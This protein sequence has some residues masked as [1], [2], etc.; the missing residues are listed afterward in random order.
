MLFSCCIEGILT[1]DHRLWTKKLNQPSVNRAILSEKLSSYLALL[2]QKVRLDNAMGEHSVNIHAENLLI[3][4]LNG[5]FDCQLQNANYVREA[6]YPALDL[7]DPERKIAFQITATSKIEKVLHTLKKVVK[8]HQDKEFESIYVFIITEKQRPEYY[9]RHEPKIQEIL[10]DKLKFDLHTHIL[11]RKELLKRIK[12][13]NDLEKL[14]QLLDELSQEFKGL[15]LGK[16]P[17]PLMAAMT[18]HPQDLELASKVCLGLL[19]KRINVYSNSKALQEEMERT[20]FGDFFMYS[21]EDI[22]PS[23]NYC[24]LLLTPAMHKDQYKFK[25]QDP[26]FTQMYKRKDVMLPCAIGIQAKKFEEM[27][28]VED[29]LSGPGK[30]MQAAID[31]I[32]KEIKSREEGFKVRDYQDFLQVLNYYKPRAKFKRV[33]GFADKSSRVGYSLYKTQDRVTRQMEYYLYL[34][35]GANLK[36]TFKHLKATH[37]DIFLK[38]NTLIILLPKARHARNIANRK[39]EVRNKFNPTNLFFIDEFLLEFCTTTQF[40]DSPEAQEFL[41]IRNFVFPYLIND[42]ITKEQEAEWIEKGYLKNWLFYPDE[43]ILVIKGWGGIGKT[44]LAR[45][46]SDMYAEERPNAKVI[47]IESQEIIEHL[48]REYRDIE[49]MD[50]YHFYEANHNSFGQEEEERMTRDLFRI[51]LDNGNILVILDGLDEIISKLP[52]FDVNRFVQSTLSYVSGFGQGKIL[53]TCRNYFW[54]KTLPFDRDLLTLKLL[55]FD[56]LKAKAFFTARYPHS[57]KLVEKAMK[58]AQGFNITNNGGKEEFLPYVLDVVGKIVESDRLLL[59]KDASFDS[60]FLNPHYKNDYLLYRICFRET[61]RIQQIS[62]DKQ[63]EFLIHFATFFNGQIHENQLEEVFENSTLQKIDR[64]QIEAFKSHPLLRVA[65]RKI[66]FQYDFF[67]EFFKSLYLSRFIE[68]DSAEEPTSTLIHLLANDCKYDLGLVKEVSNRIH[69]TEWNEE[70]ILRISY[71]LDCIKNFQSPDFNKRLINKA[72]SGL[73]TLALTLNHKHKENNPEQN[74]QLMQDLFSHPEAQGQIERMCIFNL[75][76]HSIR[77]NLEGIQLNNCHI[78]SFDS[79]WECRFDEKT[80]FSHSTIVN[81]KAPT[82]RFSAQTHNF[83]NCQIDASVENVLQ[84]QIRAEKSEKQQVADILGKYLNFF[85][86]HGRLSPQYYEGTKGI[87]WRY[88]KLQQ[89]L[90]KAD[91]ITRALI[92]EGVLEEIAQNGKSKLQVSLPFKEEVYQFSREGTMSSRINELVDQLQKL[93]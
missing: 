87:K 81:L 40:E 80:L 49:E 59:S 20:R 17:S 8:Y 22:P 34:Y 4:L 62:V 11:D 13:E 9:Q 79:F 21:Q 63:V 54:D 32:E 48:M 2:E 31:R 78:D 53:I 92:H 88:G 41:N 28:F 33:D 38:R 6:N 42:R 66:S 46:V 93:K 71:V 89:N 5:V 15:E 30:G 44:T 61:K 67:E 76:S 51:H 45:S 55:P 64:A 39:E 60:Q 57:P 65:N 35:E 29:I 77:F 1:V 72:L 52:R 85:F 19:E 83:H 43:P 91:K 23:V 16:T 37:K 69:S 68:I 12:A 47:F 14:E 70:K 25:A 3:K 10:G 82:Y 75:I 56:R 84:Q 26:I 90:F 27:P 24:I 7:I 18:F 58:V 50:I 86:S 36:Q 73:F 74:T